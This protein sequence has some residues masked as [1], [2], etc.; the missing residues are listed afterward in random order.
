MI[1]LKEVDNAVIDDI[2]FADAPKFCDAYIASA[3]YKGK[4]MTEEQLDELN[5]NSDYVY[6]QIE[7]K[8]Y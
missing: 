1:D 3:D 2:D 4:P 5:E 8:L 7:K 6:S